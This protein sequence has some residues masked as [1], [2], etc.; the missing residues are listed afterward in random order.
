MTAVLL[1]DVLRRFPLVPRKRALALPLETR[2]ARLTE[3]AASADAHS[4]LVDAAGVHNLT[5]L[6]AADRRLPDLAR[7]LCH[8]HAN[9]YLAARPLPPATA[10]LA[11]EPLVNLALLRIREADGNAAFALL[12]QLAHAVATDCDAVLD[13]TPVPLCGLTADGADRSEVVEWM[14]NVLVHDGARA[15]ARSGRWADAHVHLERI[16]GIG[17]R[18]F[19]GR[20]IAVIATAADGHF[21]LAQSLLAASPKEEPW[22]AA[23]AAA[24]TV[25]CSL[26]AGGS[27]PEQVDALLT[28]HRAVAPDDG[29][30]VFGTRL[31]LTVADLAAAAGAPEAGWRIYADAVERARA[32]REGYSA[33]DLLAYPGAAHLPVAHRKQLAAA[34]AAAGLGVRSLPADLDDSIGAALALATAVITRRVR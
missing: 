6:L 12:E 11:L 8:S 14:D 17:R 15:L 33:R 26:L 5:A 16:G 4:N 1:A 29:A 34:M 27:C 28:A 19:A 18:M 9:L 2:V 23:V 31:A 30:L 32:V 3:L 13:G 7:A 10:C 24:L 20:Q 21:E 22:E 25:A